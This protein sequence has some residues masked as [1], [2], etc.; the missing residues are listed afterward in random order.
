MKP[1]RKQLLVVFLAVTVVPATLAGW[2]AWR[3]LA[4]DRI[5]AG[6]RLREIRESRADELVQSLSRALATLARDA[7]AQPALAYAPQPR[8]LPEAP[9][10]IFSAGEQAEF[11]EGRAEDAIA[12]YRKLAES[13]RP[14]VRAGAWLRLA[15]TLRKLGRREEALQAYRQLRAIPDA[16]AGG[17]PAPLAGQWAI[18][19]MHEEAGRLAELKKE[20]ETLR[21]WLDSGRFSLGHDVYEAYAEDA[22]RWSGQPR[23]VVAEALADAAASRPSGAGAGQFRGLWITWIAADNNTV[24]LTP[25]QVQRLL[26]AGAVR[27]RFA[28]QA[29]KDE[30]LRRAAETGLP[31]TLA[32]ALADPEK[33]KQA[34]AIRR[35]L[36]FWLFGLVTALG[37]GGGYLAW[38]VIR[39]ELALVQMQADIVAAVSHEFRTPLTSMRQVSAA[40]SEGRVQDEERKQA[41]YNALARATER[42]HRLVEALLD[43]GRIESGAMEYRMQA[44]DLAAVVTGVAG[45]FGRE[46]GE[47]GFAVHADISDASS[48]GQG[49]R[50]GPRTRPVEPARQRR[51][52]SGR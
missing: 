5:M 49:R 30:S 35:Q 21:A 20:G 14:A 46:A 7:R 3:L 19:T 26:P 16:A 52:V 31:W 41:Y 50:R 36:L 42:L 27:A 18:C 13:P 15:R 11:R 2:L 29:G 24:L 1:A 34:F 44:L 39:R 45:E 43:F 38:R 32:I 12:F 48:P 17:A 47:K 33:E 25:D 10:R 28:S 40:L 9:A 6:E 8:P 51:E 23:P 22:A 37:I 4:Q